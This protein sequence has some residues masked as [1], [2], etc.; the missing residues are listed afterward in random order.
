MDNYNK[1]KKSHFLLFWKVTPLFF[2]LSGEMS[3]RIY[4]SR[5]WPQWPSLSYPLTHSRPSHILMTQ[6]VCFLCV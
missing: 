3:G 4:S 1:M 2:Q 5:P 6:F